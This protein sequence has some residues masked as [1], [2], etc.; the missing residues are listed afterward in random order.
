MKSLAEY[1]REYN[2]VFIGEAHKKTISGYF[3]QSN[4]ENLLEQMQERAQEEDD[5]EA[6]YAAHKQKQADR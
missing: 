1:G 2:T 6:R 4:I 5:R 3:D